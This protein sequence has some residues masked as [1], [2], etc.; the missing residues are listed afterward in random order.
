LAKKCWWL[1]RPMEVHTACPLAGS[2]SER[3]TRNMRAPSVRPQRSFTSPLQLVRFANTLLGTSTTLIGVG[4]LR[5]GKPLELNLVASPLHCE[6]TW[7]E[8]L[9]N[10][11][12]TSFTLAS[13]CLRTAVSPSMA[14][15]IRSRSSSLRLRNAG[16][17]GVGAGNSGFPSMPEI[18]WFNKANN[19]GGRKV[20]SSNFMFASIIVRSLCRLRPQDGF[21]ARMV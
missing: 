7:S 2:I 9:R 20:K 4:T 15:L 1:T 3:S 16:M 11:S 5:N 8:A 10:A 17:E 19:A 18:T 21:M 12:R 13:R 6:R 14:S